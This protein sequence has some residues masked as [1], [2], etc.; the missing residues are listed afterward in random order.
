MNDNLQ[1]LLN[2]YFEHCDGDWEHG[3]GIK[4][5]TIDNPGWY[6]KVSIEEIEKENL[7]FPVVDI[8]RSENDWIYCCIV[9]GI[10][11]AHGGPFNLPE[12]LQIFRDW[13][14]DDK[15]GK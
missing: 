8:N 2:W 9:E 11:E 14:E 13:I 1:W 5:G 3:N 7:N 12:I 4:I 6:L 10:F 15:N